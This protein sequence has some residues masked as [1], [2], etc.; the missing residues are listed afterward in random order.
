[1]TPI[2]VVAILA[3]PDR[4]R[5]EAMALTPEQERLF[6]A[7]L[8]Q[9]GEKSSKGRCHSWQNLP[10]VRRSCVTMAGSKGTRI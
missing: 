2:P 9:K 10:S 7:D 1:M 6:I 8:E 5:S 4:T 3:G